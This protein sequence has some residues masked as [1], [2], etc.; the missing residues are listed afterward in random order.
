MPIEISKEV[1]DQFKCY[2]PYK[3]PQDLSVEQQ[4]EM[5]YRMFLIRTFDT[6]VRDLYGWTTGYMVLLMRMLVPRRLLSAHVQH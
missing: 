2:T 5:F 4:L 6:K 3:K 1:K